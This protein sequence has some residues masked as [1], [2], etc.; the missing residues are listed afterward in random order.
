MGHAELNFM[1]DSNTISYKVVV[2]NVYGPTAAHIHAGN[3]STNGP[4][5]AF[6]YNATGPVNDAA[7]TFGELSSGTLTPAN[8]IGPAKDTTTVQAFVD[9]WVTTGD[10]YV[11]VHTAKYP[12]GNIRGQVM[13]MAMNGGMMPMSMA[14]AMAMNMAPTTAMSMAP[15]MAMPAMTPSGAMAARRMLSA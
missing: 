11:N 14:P 4:V 10:S 9:K 7:A 13:L 15:T 2:S 8:F 1:P 12:G 6:L 3:S 5:I